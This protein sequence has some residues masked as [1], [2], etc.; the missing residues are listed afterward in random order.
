MNGLKCSSPQQNCLGEYGE[1]D[2]TVLSVFPIAQRAYIHFVGVRKYLKLK[3]HSV[4]NTFNSVMWS[5]LP[6][7]GNSWEIDTLSLNVAAEAK[8]KIVRVS[9]IN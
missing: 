2:G 6:K 5:I 8:H 3:R 1:D 4:T 7:K 9:S